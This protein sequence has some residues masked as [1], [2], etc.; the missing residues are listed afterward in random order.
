M[1]R[2]RAWV[3]ALTAT[4]AVTLTACGSSGDGSGDEA[5]GSSAASGTLTVVATTN[6]YGNIAEQIGGDR[7]E[8]TSII[9]DPS[10]DPHSY[11]ADT[12][13]RL[14][15]S[16]ADVVIKNGGGYDDFVNGMTKGTDAKVLDAVTVSGDKAPAGGE[17]NEHVWYDFPAMRKLAAAMQTAFAEAEPSDASTFARNAERFDAQLATLE[18]GEAKIKAAH[19]GEGV[20]VTEPVP[21]YLLQASGLVNKTPEAFSEAIEEGDDV[22]VGVLNET[23]NLFTA[24]QVK[25]LAYN[26]QTAGPETQKVEAAAKANSVPVVSVTETLPTGKSYIQWM[27]D[28]V[29]A[30]ASALG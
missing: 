17:L 11:E 15:V 29:Q 20:A 8:V 14:A 10:Q 18:A 1:A 5:G 4:A 22:S 28:N 9:K 27:T 25:L 7:V 23:L 24:K 2:G 6:V 26:A 13:T 30:V 16:K 3:V 21:L 19:Q 12:R